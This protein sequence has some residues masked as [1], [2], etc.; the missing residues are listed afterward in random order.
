M[1]A[2]G[3]HVSFPFFKPE[4]VSAQ[5]NELPLWKRATLTAALLPIEPFTR[6]LPL[7]IVVGP[8]LVIVE[9]PS[10]ANESA[11]R[12]AIALPMTPPPITAT[13]RYLDWM[14]TSPRERYLDRV[15]GSRVG[16]TRLSARFPELPC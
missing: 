4:L 2:T 6:S 1:W 13:C 7:L 14:S 9:P 3:Y 16:P 10:S 15:H 12:H 8:V 11:A 5:D